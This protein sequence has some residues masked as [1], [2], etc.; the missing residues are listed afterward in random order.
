V[1]C[2][3]YRRRVFGGAWVVGR[4]A[5][6]WGLG[7]RPGSASGGVVGWGGGVGGGELFCVGGGGWGGGGFGVGVVGFGV[8]FCDACVGGGGG[9]L[10]VVFVGSLPSS[11]F[12][13]FFF[14]GP[15]AGGI[16]RSPKFK[17]PLR[18]SLGNMSLLVFTVCLCPT[19]SSLSASF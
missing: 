2:S 13:A 17:G 19:F 10:G 6:V 18:M 8:W 14:I 5:V 3:G 12:S 4:A 16:E 7:G 15:L 9:G 11:F 1:G